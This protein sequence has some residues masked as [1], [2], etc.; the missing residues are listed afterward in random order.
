MLISLDLEGGGGDDGRLSAT[1]AIG[2]LTLTIIQRPGESRGAAQSAAAVA[3]SSG[4]DGGEP[5]GGPAGG[6][7]SGGGRPGGGE[8]SSGGD[9]GERFDNLANVGLT[10]WQ[11]AFVL[12]EWMLRAGP[13][14]CAGR[15]AW[16]G[17]RICELGAGARRQPAAACCCCCARR[18]AAHAAPPCAPRAIAAR[19]RAAAAPTTRHAT[20]TAPQAPACWA[21]RWRWRAR[22]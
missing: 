14:A 19:P 13:A 10:V 5:A 8:P 2:P 21:W 15:D 7:P 22:T 12:G 3:S 9:P 18:G 17:V 6:P 1:Y 20:H 11:S 4:R 16:G